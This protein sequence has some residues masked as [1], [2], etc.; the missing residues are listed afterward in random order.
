VELNVCEKMR[1]V[2]NVSP[3][4]SVSVVVPSYNH[5]PF[6]EQCLRSIFEQSYAP[7]HLLVI[8]DGS[9]DGSARII[10]GVLEQCPVPCELVVRPNRGLCATLNE[11]LARSSGDL[12]AYLGSDDAWHPERLEA[13]VRALAA[14]T[15]AVLAY[16]DCYIIDGEQR[17]VGSTTDWTSYVGGSVFNHLME[18]RFVPLSPTVLYRRD[19]L[20]RFGWREDGRLEDYETYLKL[21]TLGEFAYVPRNLGYW[22]KHGSNTSRD[23]SMMLAEA[24]AAQERVA[25]WCGMPR[26]ELA[27]H[28]MRLRFAFAGDVLASGDRWTAAKLSV[29]HA[30][31]ATSF[32]GLARRGLRLLAP[33][34]LLQRREALLA[35]RSARERGSL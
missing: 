9:S 20:A 26:A 29:L 7:D 30:G 16:S 21:A 28:Q 15:R 3:R 8:D 34:A 32:G 2:E 6:V 1:K 35:R 17:I 14:N 25:E 33:R 10:A 18:V 19:A 27:R 22:R 23:V 24:L 4:P 11:G 5:A 13:G 12:F 31:G